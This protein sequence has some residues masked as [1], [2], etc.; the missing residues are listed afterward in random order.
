MPIAFEVI[1]TS[2]VDFVQ[3]LIENNQPARAE[4]SLRRL[5]GQET[6]K[7][8]QEVELIHQT[9]ENYSDGSDSSWR[10]V[11]TWGPKERKRTLGLLCK[12]RLQQTFYFAISPN[13]SS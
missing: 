8:Q 11:F 12:V 4:R 13:C 6:Q 5:H 1:G 3:W 2:D 9:I 10:S 7:I